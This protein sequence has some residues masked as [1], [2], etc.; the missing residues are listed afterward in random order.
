MSFF[1]STICCT[2]FM[3]VNHFIYL[4]CWW[5]WYWA[6]WLSTEDSDF[7]PN[8]NG[9]WYFCYCLSTELICLLVSSV[10]SH[11]W[12]DGNWSAPW[13]ALICSW[14]LPH[15][16]LSIQFKGDQKESSLFNLKLYFNSC[17]WIRTTSKGGKEVI[18]PEHDKTNKITCVQSDDGHP[19][20][21]I[22]LSC[23]KFSYL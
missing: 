16:F 3:G 19:H 10:D 5:R 12:M 6:K 8:N 2:L 20:S 4:C 13:T 11:F 9:T 7:R 17:S 1:K 23:L 21:L 22:S 15:Q 14:M 18:E